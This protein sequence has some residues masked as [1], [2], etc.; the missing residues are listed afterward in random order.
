MANDLDPITPTNASFDAPASI[1]PASDVASD[2]VPPFLSRQNEPAAPLPIDPSDHSKSHVIQPTV[3][4]R[5]A[6]PR[7]SA[8]QEQ[9]QDEADALRSLDDT[10]I[11]MTPTQP[12][13]W[14][15]TGD[16]R[17]GKV[18]HFGRPKVATI[19]LV[20]AVAFVSFVAGGVFSRLSSQVPLLFP[21]EAEQQEL[22]LKADK[23]Y[24]PIQRQEEETESN[25]NELTPT[26]EPETAPEQP[27]PETPEQTEQE[28]SNDTDLRWEFDEEGDRSVSYDYDTDQITIDYDGY[29]LV[30]DLNYLWG[31]PHGQAPSDEGNNGRE[32]QWQNDFGNDLDANEYGPYNWGSS[33][34]TQGFWSNNFAA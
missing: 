30:F 34:D 32:P 5:P 4:R 3:I 10:G 17:S 15:S 11:R 13:M 6:V 16:R 21:K 2:S 33:D 26:Y 27:E 23:T 22:T 24:T 12:Y 29:E 9:A 25:T 19:A 31:D 7:P 8:A 1:T 14:D 28:P 18:H 20:G